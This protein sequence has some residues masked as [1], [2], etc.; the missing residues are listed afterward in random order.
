VAT[1]SAGLE[2]FLVVSVATGTVTITGTLAGSVTAGAKVYPGLVGRIDQ[3]TKASLITS[4][5]SGFPVSFDA[6]PGTRNYPAQGVP[7][8]DGAITGLSRHVSAAI[9]GS[10]TYYTIA[11][12]GLT[13]AMVDTGRVSFSEVVYAKFTDSSG[14]P[15]GGLVSANVKCFADNGAGAHA[16]SAL[17][18]GTF[19]STVT[20]T[21]EATQTISIKLLPGTRHVGLKPQVLSTIPIYTLATYSVTNTISWL[22]EDDSVQGYFKETPIFVLKPNWSTAVSLTAFGSLE[23]VDYD[24]GVVENYSYLNWNAVSTQ[25]TFMRRDQAEIDRLV[26]L[27]NDMHGQQGEF[28]VPTWLDDFDIS[29]GAAQGAYTLTTPGL[30]VFQA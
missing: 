20:I 30:T 21:G 28:Y 16:T 4:R 11:Q 25:A 24:N 19:D 26:T 17:L 13:A 23:Q 8:Y 3:N 14:G 29:L 2:A 9:G 27:F 1:T 10:T 12:L 22:P 5:A 18:G 15:M 7:F 6:D